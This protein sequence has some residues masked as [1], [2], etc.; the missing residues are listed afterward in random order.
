[1]ITNRKLL[2]QQVSADLRM[3]GNKNIDTINYQE[4]ECKYIR[5]ESL[6][7]KHDIIVFDEV[8]YLLSDSLFNRNTDLLLDYLK[9][10]PKNKLCIFMSATPEVIL[11]YCNDFDFTYSLDSDY[12]Y[13]DN[14]YFFSRED[15]Y[16]KILNSIPAG[17]KC[18][19]FCS[20]AKEAYEKSLQYNNAEFICS[21]Y[22]QKYYSKSSSMERANLIARDKFNCKI[23]FTTKVL[24]NGVNIKDKSLKHIIIDMLDPVSFIQCLGRKRILDE[25]DKIK[26]YIKNYDNRNLAGISIKF[27]DKLKLVSELNEL[28]K[29]EF[30]KKYK[31]KNFDSIIDNDITVNKAK[32]YS[33]KYY[34][35]LYYNLK[36]D[37]NGKGYMKYICNKLKIPVKDVLVLEEE[38]ERKS[39]EKII[40]EYLGQK[41]LLDSQRIFKDKFFNCILIPKET[42]YRRRGIRSINGILKELGLKYCLESKVTTENKQSFRY[43]YLERIE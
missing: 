42:N 7:S 5:G 11:Y 24:D 12:S 4:L 21:E 9:N 26:L 15:S 30:L 25:N 27:S 41:I 1:M 31:K 10:P 36:S 43:W 19:C 3:S 34:Q 6:F 20:S 32:Y 40:N 28:G 38:Y 18:L 14:I 2:R 8:H 39:I 37:E 23:L 17:E 16:K 33:Y 29:D 22:N 35:N 13:I